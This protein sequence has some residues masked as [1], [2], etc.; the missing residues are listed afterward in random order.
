MIQMVRIDHIEQE[1]NEKIKI[2]EESGN[3]NIQIDDEDA[4]FMLSL[5]RKSF[6]LVVNVSSLKKYSEPISAPWIDYAKELKT[7]FMDG[8]LINIKDK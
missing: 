1:W 8:K 2:A 6:I 4:K 5:F 7:S 3:N